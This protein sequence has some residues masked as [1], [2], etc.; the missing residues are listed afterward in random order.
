MNL[1]A[2]LL[3]CGGCGDRADSPPVLQSTE[4]AVTVEWEADGEKVVLD[5]QAPS[6]QALDAR[7]T[8]GGTEHVLADVPP[9]LVYEVHST[10]SGNL[11]DDDELETVMIVSFITGAGPAGSTPFTVSVVLDCSDDGLRRLP[12]VEARLGQ[13]P[14]PDSVQA[15]FRD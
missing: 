15:L 13:D 2:M 12:L 10:H 5:V 9:W 11:D 1:V 6:T 8:R 7:C 14:D 3:A 4:H